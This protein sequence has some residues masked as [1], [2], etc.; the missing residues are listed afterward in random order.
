MTSMLREPR[1]TAHVRA[2]VQAPC[3]AADGAALVWPLEARIDR[4]TLRRFARLMAAEGQPLQ[5]ARL[6]YDRLYA[7]ECCACAHATAN[8]ALR[9]AALELFA[10]YERP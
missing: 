2:P 9:S 4:S 8:A 5:S 6:G 7:I 10:P 3:V 1:T